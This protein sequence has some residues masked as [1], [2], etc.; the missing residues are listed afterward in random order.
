M[1]TKDEMKQK[2]AS[3]FDRKRNYQDIL[4]KVQKPKSVMPK[5][6][7]AAVMMTALVIAVLVPVLNQKKD[8]FVTSDEIMGQTE[9]G[10]EVVLNINLPEE[11]SSDEKV[12]VNDIAPALRADT[13]VEVLSCEKEFDFLDA[14]CPQNYEMSEVSRLIV[15]S[16]TTE[17]MIADY[18][19]VQFTKDDH[20]ITLKFSDTGWP[21]RDCYLSPDEEISV[22]DGVEMVIS[23]QPEAEL[24]LTLF[25]MN[26]SYYD[27]ESEH[28]GENELV[29][30]LLELV[31]AL[32]NDQ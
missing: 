8:A 29:L 22:L 2:Y 27:V 9:L 25:E 6:R 11:A 12:I 3:E 21:L 4:K 24:Y 30:F 1:F 18:Y 15:T 13:Q 7:M 20:C 23:Y 32:R 10:P 19:L 17:E 26:D 16:Q 31:S 5:M 14:V 28:I